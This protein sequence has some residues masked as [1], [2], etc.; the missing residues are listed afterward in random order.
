MRAT[1]TSGF[2]GTWVTTSDM[3][4]SV[5]ELHIQAWEGDGLS[6]ISVTEHSTQSMKFDGK[7]YPGA[8]ADA[9]AGLRSSGRRVDERTLEIA[10]KIKGVV[11]KRRQLKLSADHKTLMITMQPVG[12]SK[13]SIL[14]FDR[15]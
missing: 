1:E 5:F 8:D 13:P 9:V 2:S 3:M 10:D 15:Q 14:V 4:N 12:Q 7:D 6:F 11:A